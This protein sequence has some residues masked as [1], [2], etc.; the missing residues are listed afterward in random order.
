MLA[1]WSWPDDAPGVDIV[2]PG[3]AAPRTGQSHKYGYVR[4]RDSTTTTTTTATTTTTRRRRADEEGR[5]RRGKGGKCW[6][7]AACMRT[8][9]SEA[10]RA[11]RGSR[12]VWR[13]PKWGTSGRGRG[14]IGGSRRI[15]DA[16]MHHRLVGHIELHHRCICDR[17][18]GA[19]LR[20][21]IIRPAV[22]IY[23]DPS[24]DARSVGPQREAPMHAQL[25]LGP[26]GPRHADARAEVGKLVRTYV[27]TYVGPEYVRT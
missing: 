10:L 11:C 21:A 26:W 16:S 8:S 23:S 18:C 4:I 22:P 7:A 5:R 24:W 3:A 2:A 25:T 13:P 12:S 27:R 6:I 14:R 20:P 19:I 15:A 1:S 17:G 9:P